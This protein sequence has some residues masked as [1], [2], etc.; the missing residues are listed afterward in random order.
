MLITDAAAENA[1]NSGSDEDEPT[2]KQSN[3][4]NRS[5]NA[6]SRNTTDSN[7]DVFARRK[8]RKP[9]LVEIQNFA[10]E[11]FKYVCVFYSVCD[12]YMYC[13]HCA[14]LFHFC[15]GLLAGFF[16]TSSVINT[17]PSSTKRF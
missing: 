7:S 11:M 3:S 4:R 10:K 9:R 5:R 17:G 14:L 2:A 13:T 6:R 16:L 15:M 12:F 1:T 8:T